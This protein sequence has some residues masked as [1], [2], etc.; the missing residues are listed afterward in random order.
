M[1][2]TVCVYLVALAGLAFAYKHHFCVEGGLE[3]SNKTCLESD[4]GICCGSLSFLLTRGLP[5]SSEVTI[6]HDTALNETVYFKDLKDIALVGNN[7]TLTCSKFKNA[8]LVFNSVTGLEILNVTIE[9]CGSIQNMTHTLKRQP[10][11]FMSALYIL[12]SDT[13][14]F[15]RVRVVN[16]SGSGVFLSDT[17]GTV[18]FSFCTFKSNGVNSSL[19]LHYSAGG[20][21]RVE[22][23]YCSS[24]LH[25]NCSEAKPLMSGSRYVFNECRFWK[26]NASTVHPNTT[27]FIR[28]SGN[29]IQGI[30]DGGGLSVSIKG[31]ASNNT[32]IVNN[33]LFQNNSAVWGG[34]LFIFFQD[35]A[36]NNSVLI[37][38]A[39]VINNQAYLYGGGGAD[40]GYV[41]ARQDAAE[42]NN[43]TFFNCSFHSNVAKTAGGALAVFSNFFSTAQSYIEFRQCNFTE[44]RARFG[45]AVEVAPEV[46]ETLG[47]GK[48]LS[49]KFVDCL[50]KYNAVIA[51]AKPLTA[52]GTSKGARYLQYGIGVFL[53]SRTKVLFQ[54]DVVFTDNTGTALYLTSG[55]VE[56]LNGSYASFSGNHGEY[57]GA[58]S[59]VGYSSIVVNDHSKFDFLRN[60]AFTQGGAIHV[61]CIDEHKY[62]TDRSCFVQYGGDNQVPVVD[63][64]ITFNFVDNF[65]PTGDGNVIYA[66]S[67][68]PCAYVCSS[69]AFNSPPYLHCIVTVHGQIGENANGK[70]NVTSKVMEYTL[71]G[72]FNGSNLIPGKY[73]SIPLTAVDEFG[74]DKDIAYQISVQNVKYPSNDTFADETINVD[75]TAN[76]LQMFGHSG[77]SG[78]LVL[79]N[80]DSVLLFNFSLDDC[81]PGYLSQER[82]NISSCYC[83]VLKYFGLVQCNDTETR[84][85]MQRAYWM[86]YCSESQQELCTGHCPLGFCTYGFTGVNTSKSIGILLP[87]NASV[88]DDFICDSHRTGVLCG[89]CKEN[90][91]AYYHSP[92]VRCGDETYCRWGWLFYVLSELVPVTILFLIVMLFSVSFT[93]GKATGFIL[94]AQI[95]DSQSVSVGGLIQFPEAVSM[96]QQLCQIMYGFFNLN[97]F[98]IEELSFCLW[99][100]AS[101]LDLIAMKYVT[102]VYALSLVVISVFV[103]RSTRLMQCFSCLRVRTL[104][105]AFIHGI[106]AFLIMC[107]SQCANT[108]IKLLATTSLYSAGPTY[109]SKVLSKAGNTLPFHSDH[110][111]YAIPSLFFIGVI[112]TMLPLLLI[113]YPLVFKALSYC[114]L[115][116]TRLVS[117]VYRLIPIQ[118]LDAFQGCYKD[119]FRFFAGFYFLYRLFILIA[120]LCI[121]DRMGRLSVVEVIIFSVLTLHAVTQPY[122]KRLHNIVDS[123]IFGNLAFINAITLVNFQLV[124]SLMIQLDTYIAVLSFAQVVLIG[125][126]LLVVVCFIIGKFALKL[127]RS[128]VSVEMVSEDESTLPLLRDETD[129]IQA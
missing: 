127:R 7:A 86:G 19:A 118:I 46:W 73:F 43:I 22:F 75:G 21:V 113:V 59:L 45:S 25:Q 37:K 56:F 38:N 20:G 12:N 120:S 41:F 2:A 82:N 72:S 122:K 88:L 11:R 63:R 105:V 65:T 103:M 47:T 89:S 10:V 67:F 48:F 79:A 70:Y 18:K 96:L 36:K 116:E 28:G 29:S 125:L 78:L 108:S 99:K 124:R 110:L 97:F 94:F 101:A 104:K 92:S 121:S 129:S 60:I 102:V 87:Q 98:A 40:V 30:G 91:S 35:F 61:Q 100:G 57:G 64:N 128:Q 16:S 1:I 24:G 117:A 106:T 49:P 126:P 90:Y 14:T 53:V 55:T 69:D 26:N 80:D 84:A 13:I 23:T 15:D 123:L 112:V 74:N 77:G 33:C 107:Y 3:Q 17:N 52:S 54:G 81:P 109:D 5:P 4:S 62:S 8:G 50:F 83:S 66:G 68:L 111:K 95:M 119:C 114:R 6:V 85:Y 9:R 76:Q 39:S 115:N 51:I 34:G 31:R 93:S 71:D 27:S 32:F 42:N 44:N 58:V